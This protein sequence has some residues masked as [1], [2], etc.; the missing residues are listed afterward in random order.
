LKERGLK[1]VRLIVG[2]RCLGL[3][4]SLAEFYPTAAYQRCVVH[5]YRNVW[6]LVPSTKISE[7]SA[8]LKAIHA[9]GERAAARIKAAQVVAK[10]R[11]MKLP[12]AAPAWWARFPMATARLSS[13]AR[14]CAT[15]PAR[16][17][18]NAATS[19]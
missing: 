10:L 14:A 7:V 18:A 1:G 8:M 19:T 4:E 13:W 16:T 15:S 17:G 9:S 2:D 12:A 11:E 6:S 3:V 5:F